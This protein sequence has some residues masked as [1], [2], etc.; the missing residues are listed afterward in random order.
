MYR[1]CRYDRITLLC[2][3]TVSELG[4]KMNNKLKLNHATFE[5][6]LLQLSIKTTLE[7]ITAKLK[8]FSAFEESNRIM[9]LEF[10]D[11]NADF[12]HLTN[13]L[14]SICEIAKEFDI[15][16]HGIQECEKLDVAMVLD[17]PVLNLPTIDNKN[18]AG[19]KTLMIDE[20][21]RSGIKIENNGDIV[22]SSFV[23]D[24]AEVI[25]TGNIHVYGEARGRLIAGNGGDK[26]ARIF[27]NSFNA[28]FIAIGGIY[29]AL[30]TKL[31]E[32]IL[33]KA[34]MVSLDDKERLSIVPL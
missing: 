11:Y 10:Y 13:L 5:Y 27:A 30:D 32:N 22:V 21:V 6:Y 18:N 26:A 34:V 7:Q 31:P 23:S 25:A 12:T 28:E 33:R 8:G 9:V 24:N 29:R 3:N 2:N 17:L 1:K 16:I 4:Q 20:P 14:L 15:K 19:K